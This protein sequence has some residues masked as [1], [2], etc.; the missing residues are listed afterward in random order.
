M[1]RMVAGVEEDEEVTQ[2]VIDIEMSRG[3]ITKNDV[4]DPFGGDPRELV[5]IN[6]SIKKK[7]TRNETKLEK[8]LKG[9]DGAATKRV[10]EEI[11]GYAYLDVVPTP[12]NI[13]MLTK[14]PDISPYH[15]A[16]IEAKVANIVGLGFRLTESRGAQRKLSGVEDEA[17]LSKMRRKMAAHRDE[18]YDQIDEL[19]DDDGLIDVL[20][21]VWYDYEAVGMGYI[22]IGRTDSGRIGYVGHIPANTIR[23]R[24]QRDGYVQVI[25]NKAVFFRN[26]GEDTPNPIGSDQNCNE[27]IMISSY[28]PNNSYYGTPS[29]ISAMTAIAG[30]EFAERFNID[31]FE[32]KAVPRH[33]IVV[34]G[35][36]LSTKGKNDLFEFFET[37]L[38]GKNHRSLYVPL[39]A[40]SANSKTSIEIKPIEAGTQDASFERYFKLNASQI[41]LSHRTPANKVGNFENMSVAAA[42]DATKTFRDQVCV[43]GQRM[44][45]RKVNKIIKEFTEVFVLEFNELTLTDEDTQSKIDERYLRNKVIVPNEVRNRM[46]KAGIPGG[47]KVIDLSPKQATDAKVSQSGNRAQASERSAA[48]STTA[49][50]GRNAKG[51][52]RASDTS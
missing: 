43:P 35:A 31:Y 46:D 40:D 33:L 5:G 10:D 8:S 6:A 51:E 25:Q 39:P 47:D 3:V 38:K 23:V 21:K 49:A 32:N 2:H 36:T 15:A 44:L 52:G 24:R 41:L 18:L 12:Y 13:G 14:L 37:S 34:K 28:S 1:P 17:K 26:F 29:I 50:N 45:G 48:T 9:V 30:N 4:V 11:T 22:E 19:N 7:A 27:I 16:A 20:S 42:L